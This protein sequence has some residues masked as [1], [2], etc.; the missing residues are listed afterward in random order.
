LTE[1]RGG[2]VRLHLSSYSA[3]GLVFHAILPRRL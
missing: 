2:Q 3:A 1:R